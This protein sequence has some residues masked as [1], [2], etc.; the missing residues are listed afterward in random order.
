M[1]A[2]NAEMAWLEGTVTEPPWPVFPQEDVRPRYRLRLTGEPDVVEQVQEPEEEVW[3]QTA[4][5]WLRQVQGLGN[6][7]KCPWLRDVVSAYM[8]WTIAANGGDLS[9]GEEADDAPS[10]WN[11]IFFALAARCTRVLR[12]DRGVLS[13]G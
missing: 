3:H 6:A 13:G 5:L 12:L 11:D 7:D 8:S 10:Q 1:A 4:A 9:R 2:V